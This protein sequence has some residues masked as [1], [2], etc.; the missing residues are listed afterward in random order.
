MGREHLEPIKPFPDDRQLIGMV[1]EGHAIH[2]SGGGFFKCRPTLAT[3]RR[4]KQQ[5]ALSRSLSN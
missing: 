1:R 3:W 4:T 5:P 2:F